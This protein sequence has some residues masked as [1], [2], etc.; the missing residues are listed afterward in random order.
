V[1]EPK[2]ISDF[3]NLSRED[4]INFTTGTA[5]NPNEVEFQLET[6]ASITSGKALELHSHSDS[7]IH[8]VKTQN[9]NHGPQQF[10]VPA[11][12][13]LRTRLTLTKAKLLGIHTEMYEIQNLTI[14]KGRSLQFL[15]QSDDDRKGR[16]LGFLRDLGNAIGTATN[17]IA[18]VIT[19]LVHPVGEIVSAIFETIGNWLSGILNA[20]GDSLGRIPFIGGFLRG[21]LRWLGTIVSAFFDFFATLIKGMLNLVANVT[22]G[23]LRIIGGS[24]GGLLAWDSRLFAR[25]I[26]DFLSGIVGA[27]LSVLGKLVAFIQ[28]VIFM[29]LGERPLTASERALL[30]SVY[31]TS[32][33]LYNV[34]IVDGFAGLFSTNSRPFTLGNKIYMKHQN[35]M[36]Y[37]S[38]LVHECCHVWQ[39]QH[40]GIRYIAGA[41]WAQFTLP[42]QGYSWEDELKRGHFRWQDF[43]KEAQAQ[44][45]Q[46]VFDSGQQIPPK[47][48]PG[49]FYID[50]PVGDN[51]LFTSSGTDYTGLAR[52]SV[53]YVRGI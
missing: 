40:E 42:G 22:A 36:T 10:S 21:L 3:P 38:T 45:L 39:N 43:N 18:N 17:A 32:V 49:E 47:G 35:S 33:R 52:E 11:A 4:I 31:R 48:S 12:N 5:G 2:Q 41:L 9:T 37:L 44:F 28:A 8:R 50:D 25:G 7:I 14:Y 16:F 20:I 34:R 51:V 23:L 30:N 46:N 53:T 6:A 24:I 29:Q 1:S 27:L 19:G 26:G 13:L 15:W